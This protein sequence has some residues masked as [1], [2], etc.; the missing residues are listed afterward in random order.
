MTPPRPAG[1]SA[2]AAWLRALR[3]DVYLTDGTKLLLTIIGE[4]MSNDGLVKYS[5]VDLANE[6]GRSERAIQRHL[7]AARQAGWLHRVRGGHNGAVSVYQATLPNARRETGRQTP[8]GTEPVSLPSVRA[9]TSREKPAVSL[10]RQGERSDRVAVDRNA[11]PDRATSKSGQ[12]ERH[13]QGVSPLVIAAY[14]SWGEE[15][16]RS[17]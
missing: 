10:N 4:R 12:E 15:R 16:P 14:E 8:T 11:P 2:K 3:R 17:A 1:A 9:E 7:A 13:P 6:L 5:R